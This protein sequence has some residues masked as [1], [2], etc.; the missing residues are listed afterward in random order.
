VPKP[1]G[2]RPNHAAHLDADRLR[3]R[4]ILLQQSV[5]QD[6]VGGDLF[7]LTALGVERALG[8]RDQQTEHQGGDGCDQ[9]DAEPHDV[10]G[11]LAEMMLRQRGAQQRAEHDAAQR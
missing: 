10:L 5:E 11:V 8:R 9:P 1:V 3:F 2:E 6:D 7:D 4:A